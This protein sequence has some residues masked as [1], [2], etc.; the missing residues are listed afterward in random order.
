MYLTLYK[1]SNKE[2]DVIT[3][4]IMSLKTVE[5]QT[6]LIALLEKID[7]EGFKYLVESHELITKKLE[8]GLF[9]IKVSKNR[10]LYCY[11]EGNQVHIVHAFKKSTQK[12]PQKDL[13]LARRRIK[14]L[15]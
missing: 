10:F 9:E 1:E 6:K 3:T 15:S 5:E 7:T 2:Y 14:E 4:Y 11:R 13:K 12:T 8:D